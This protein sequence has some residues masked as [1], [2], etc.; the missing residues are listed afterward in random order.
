M[1]I[2][3]DNAATTPPPSPAPSIFI[4]YASEDRTAARALRDTL[5]E[6]GL[7]VWYDEN[8]LG[9]GDSWDQKIR[10]QI[11]DCEYFMPVISATTEARKEGY[12]RREWRLATDRSLDMADDVLF[13][14]PVTIDGTNEQG[15]R[16]PDKFLTVQWLRLPGGNATP[17]LHHLVRRILSGNHHALTRPPMAFNRP[18]VTGATVAPFGQPPPFAEPPPLNAGA[19]TA[20][21][22]HFDDSHPDAPPR[23]PPMPHVPEKGGFLHGVKFIFEILWWAL[24]AAWMLFK[25]LPRWARIIVIIWIVI[26]MFSARSCS[27]GSGSA[28]NNRSNRN[29]DPDAEITRVDTEKAIKN[30]TDNFAQAAREAR[31]NGNSVDLA[32]L[33]NE[34]AKSFA[35]ATE[36][37]SGPGN[38]FGKRIVMVPFSKPGTEDPA[39]KFGSA[40]FASLFGQLTLTHAREVGLFKG[41]PNINDPAL[42]ARAKQFGS[43]FVLTGRL[44]GEGDARALTVRLLVTEDGSTKW[45]E[46]FPV[47]GAEPSDVADKIADKADDV[48][49]RREP[50][51]PP[52]P[53]PKP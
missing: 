9:G 21:A 24:T 20:S 48:L 49:P 14:I 19:A 35:G 13:L 45:T 26:T 23:M 22:G 41:P 50:R 25:R 42:I 33:G 6:A 51:P 43:A 47:A 36:T 4:S 11:R 7:D 52:T 18:P 12:F 32:R 30:A 29:R 39:E 53:N 44:S 15:A 28:N 37:P 2:A 17:A 1:S 8:E 27:T 34:I 38:P 10:R 31:K 46:S 40:V 5:T 16:V 3:S